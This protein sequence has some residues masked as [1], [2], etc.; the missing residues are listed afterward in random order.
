MAIKAD[1]ESLRLAHEKAKR[2]EVAARD[3]AESLDVRWADMQREYQGQQ[4]A[5]RD[6]LRGSV[7]A[8]GMGLQ[9]QQASASAADNGGARR[10]ASLSPSVEEDSSFAA[11]GSGPSPSWSVRMDAMVRAEADARAEAQRLQQL[12][13]D[14]EAE[15]RGGGASRRMAPASPGSP[16]RPRWP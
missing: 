15:L 9:Q 8:A 13:A 7:A 11:G 5:A 3:A 16:P 12:L 4:E 1:R 6:R 14:Q 2:A 10:R